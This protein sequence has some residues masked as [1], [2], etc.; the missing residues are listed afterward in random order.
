MLRLLAGEGYRLLHKK[1]MY[2]YFLALGLGYFMLAFIR[3]GGFD[4]NSLIKEALNFFMFLP[5]LVG[6][7]LFAAIYTDDLAS[8]NLITLVGFGIGKTKIVLAKLL[9]SVILCV[10]I[11]ALVVLYL[12]GVFALLGW[13]ASFSTMM[14]FV[15]VAVKY[16]LMS[17]A[18]CSLGAVVV[19]GFQR[20]TFAM[21]TYILLAFSIVSGFITVLANNLMGEQVAL[22]F[23]DRLMPGLT[24]RIMAGMLGSIGLFGPLMEYG[25]Y[26]LITVLITVIVFNKK[27]MEF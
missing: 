11:F 23:S 2:V 27:E 5:P 17:V 22:L 12:F 4:E 26:L 24:D 8:R 25:L 1:S 3:S 6:G 19:Y 21:V 18:Y 13:V 15:V 9:L 7:Y 16:L 20:T 10:L 14:R